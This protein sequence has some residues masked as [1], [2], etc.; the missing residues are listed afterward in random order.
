MGNKNHPAG[1]LQELFGKDVHTLCIPQKSIIILMLSD[2]GAMPD[3]PHPTPANAEPSELPWPES[4]SSS[5]QT[6]SA[7]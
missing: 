4:F 5:T 3:P 2:Q 6:L 1:L 7:R